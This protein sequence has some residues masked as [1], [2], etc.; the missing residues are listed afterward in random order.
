MDKISIA[1]PCYNEEEVIP[2]FYNEIIK[3]ADKMKEADFEFLFIDDGS[4]DNTLNEIK[5]LADKD[6][7]VKYISFSRNFGKESAIYAGLENSTGDYIVIMDVDLQ[8]PPELIIE[9]YNLICKEGYDCVSTR[10]VTRRGEPRLRS[11]FANCFYKL[12]NKMSKTK[13]V[14]GARDYRM[15]KRKMVQA[16]VKMTEYNRF[17]KG[18]FS[19]VGF[20]TKW[21]DYENKERVAGS[22]KWSFWKL[23][24]YSLEG[25]MAFSTIPLALASL[26]GILFCLIAFI[27]IVVIIIR[28]LI[29]GDP[30]GGWP[31]LVCIISLIGG[32]QLFC[33]G[34][35]GQYIAKIYLE[36][37]NRPKYI[38]NENN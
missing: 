17:S 19:W 4:A 13:I 5:K 29:W 7:R 10:R 14:N 26:M 16:I 12:I 3:T 32:I 24:V 22:T 33:I 27:L 18:I 38:I 23:F 31:S 35:V 1:V 25:I 11:F 28:T 9:M 30:T 20:K 2:I 8:D 15:M 21:L 36:T 37:K 6:K 34:I